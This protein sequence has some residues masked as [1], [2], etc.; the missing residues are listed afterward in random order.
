VRGE[1]DF[2]HIIADPVGYHAVVARLPFNPNMFSSPPPMPP[3]PPSPPSP[4]RS[5]GSGDRPLTVTQLAGLVKETLLQGLPQKLRIIGQISNLSDRTHWFFNLKDAGASMRCVCFASN[6]RRV[7]FPVK[8]GME[9]IAT[10]RIDFYD[11][12]GN[13]QFYVDKLDPVGVGELELRYRALCDELRRLGYFEAERKKPLPVMPLGVAVVTSKTGAALADVI[14]T[15]HKRWP[16]CRLMLLDVRVQ[17][18]AAA[19]EIAS[20]LNLLSRHGP[21]LGVDAIILTRGGG[22]MEDLWAFN[23]RIVADAVYRCGLPIVAAIGHETDITIAELVADLRCATPTQAAMTLIPDQRALEDQVKQLGQRLR[24]V[25]S[26]HVRHDAQR[27]SAVEWHPVFRRPDQ[28]Y[29]PTRQRI[30]ALAARLAMGLPRSVR[31]RREMVESLAA[32]LAALLPRLLRGGIDEVESLAL[33]LATG[34]RRRVKTKREQLEA[35]ARQLD[36]ISPL[37]VLKRGYTYT[38]GS[39]GKVLR[40]AGEVKPGDRLTTVL[41]DGRV[42]SIAEGGGPAASP[43]ARPPAPASIIRPRKKASRDVE[44]G[45]F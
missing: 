14:N 7:S 40:S 36:S 27:L 8:D 12:Q 19:P 17:G 2:T 44:P 24:L 21:R 32:R 1:A 34:L 9:V 11:A 31:G 22:S 33:R 5:R 30:E 23:E 39:D 13:V 45:L 42:A 15:A 10:G 43:Q 3:A 4:S 41:G 28:M 35:L 6:A 20:A 38:L 37:E 25:M 29:V 26:R 16:G 18:A